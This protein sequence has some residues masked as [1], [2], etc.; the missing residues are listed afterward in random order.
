M[1]LA[2]ISLLFSAARQ[3]LPALDCINFEHDFWAWKLNSI[4]FWR[5]AST[6]PDN[7]KLVKVATPPLGSEGLFKADDHR[8][9]SISAPNRTE[10]LVCKP[11]N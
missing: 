10:D 5:L 1:L 6:L 7:P 8:G 9:Y 4:K 11:T 3:D 2:V